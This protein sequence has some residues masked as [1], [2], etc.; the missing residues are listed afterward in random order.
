MNCYATSGQ[1]AHDFGFTHGQVIHTIET[2]NM[3]AI[4]RQHIEIF[5]F[6]TRKIAQMSA[7]GFNAV[8]LN[9]PLNCGGNDTLLWSWQEAFLSNTPP[10]MAILT[11]RVQGANSNSP[12][13]PVVMDAIR[14][15]AATQS[16][17]GHV[18]GL[19]HESSQSIDHSRIEQLT[20]NPG[21]NSENRDGMTS[22]TAVGLHNYIA[23]HDPQSFVQHLQAIMLAI[24]V[25]MELTKEEALAPVINGVKVYFEE[26]G[27][28]GFQTAGQ[29]H[30][31]TEFLQAL[32]DMIHVNFE[33]YPLTT[34]GLNSNLGYLY[35]EIAD[36]PSHFGYFSLISSGQKEFNKIWADE[37]IPHAKQC[38]Y[39]LAETSSQWV[40]VTSCWSH[41]GLPWVDEV[42]ATLP[43]GMGVQEALGLITANLTATQHTYVGFCGD[44]A[45]VDQVRISVWLLIKQAN[46]GPLVL[47]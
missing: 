19:W 40:V 26:D 36:Q 25:V 8:V 37:V 39:D 44:E 33:P 14:G 16:N 17:Q 34:F 41:Y 6:G 15:Q 5:D 12:I 27:K 1:I 13:Q 22:R 45:L 2:L 28:T 18:D 21:N 20:G 31:P 7:L 38:G 3:P 43:G 35:E 46:Q 10:D 24:D 9:L 30:R 11:G 42:L 32:L 29:F 23:I 47:N 4:S